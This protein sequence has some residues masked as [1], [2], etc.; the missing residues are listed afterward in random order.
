MTAHTHKSPLIVH[1]AHPLNAE[2]PGNLLQQSFLTPQQHFFVRTH[3]SIPEIDPSRYRLLLTGLVQQPRAFSLDEL[4]S[5]APARTVPVTLECAGNRRT[6]IMA[7]KPLGGEVPWGAGAISTA[8]WLGIPLREVLR[9]VGVQANARYV[10]FTGLD[11]APFAGETVHFGSSIT[12]GK[13]LSQDV[14]LA[15]EMNDEPLTPEHGFP[16]RL[17][18]PGYIGARSV[19]WLGE[20]TLQH[21]PS[22]NPYQTRDYKLFPSEVTAQTADW[23]RG[24]TLESLVLNAVITTP[25]A[26]ETVAAG[27]VQVRGYAISGEEAP[28]ERVELSVDDG[29]TWKTATIVERAGPYAWCF[30][31][32]SLSLPPGD[33]Q[34]IVRAWDTSKHTQPEDVRNLWNFKGYMN[35]ACHRV[36]IHLV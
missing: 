7:V 36:T 9:A 5:L 21:H 6:E 28:V 24:K 27:R 4:R 8:N 34:L 14:L 33:R 3:G 12:L 29:Q 23:S 1:R 15:Y 18:V 10:A 16:L 32:L 2:P 31:E 19:K 17:I 22:T 13:A 26:G 30:W 25:Q 11:E 20:I 35:N